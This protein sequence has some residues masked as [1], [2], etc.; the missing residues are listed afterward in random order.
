M[1][2]I[3][4]YGAYIPIYRIN[5][6]SIYQALGWLNP[7][8]LLPG[9]KAVA[10]YDED[11]L[12]MAVAASMDCLNGVDREIIDGMFLA[13][14]TT[15]YK[16]R[17]NAGIIATAVDLRS[18][19]RTSD[20][21]TSIK[22]GTG[23]LISA[24]DAVTSGS[25]KNVIVCAADCRLGKPGG[26][27]EEI[28]GDGAAAFVL[29]DTDVIASIE[30]TYSVSY[31]F[32]DNWR[33]TEDRY[34]RTWEDRWVRDEGYVKFITEAI[35][36]LMQKYSLAPNDVAK[37]VYPCLYIA[38]HA[39]I[40]R[41]LGFDPAQIQDHMFTTVGN[42]GTAYP[43]M[44]LVAALE[45][46]KPG[47]NIIVASYGNGSDA[48]LLKVTDKIETVKGR[49]GIKGHLAA[50]KDL[51][52]YEKYVTFREVLDIDTGGRGEEIASTQVSTMWR[53]RSM[54][55]GLCGSKCQRCGT[56]QYP[57]QQICAN[58]DC[59]AINEM[60]SYRFSDK[61]GSLFTYTSDVLAFSPSPPAIYGMV[62]FEG[63]GRWLFDLNDCELESLEVGMPV[64]MSLRRK[65]HDA[66][67][68]VHVYFW[69]ATPVR[70]Q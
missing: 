57:P 36:G 63:G 32:M 4:S 46:A 25:A 50:K 70:V 38:A 12:T 14:T 19:I 60:D 9:E 29:G 45:D 48:L 69:K 2:G 66:N 15:P 37:V 58:P 56:P 23:A 52:S 28:Y 55:L 11:S 61:K 1:A 3:T 53:E 31:D 33:A 17:Q 21:T 13:T 20:F 34:N 18:D 5:R 44:I 47:D 24:Y 16:E 7:A 8:S 67:R 40:G 10:N 26:F 30:G 27:Q 54:I 39:S 59:G 49:R 6:M 43:L 35:S 42:T 64:E 62:D 41:K 51:G 68:G 22:S 65:Y